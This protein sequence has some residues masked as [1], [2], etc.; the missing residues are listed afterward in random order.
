MSAIARL[1]TGCRNH[2]A[3]DRPGSLGEIL[4]ELVVQIALTWNLPDRQLAETQ[5]RTFNGLGEIDW[6]GSNRAVAPVLRT[7]FARE[8]LLI[9]VRIMQ[10]IDFAMRSQVR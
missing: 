8:S 3:R 9:Q 4:P 7:S 6:V 1:G 10:A 5:H 2:V